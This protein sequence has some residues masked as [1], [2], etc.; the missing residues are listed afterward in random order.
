MDLFAVMIL[1]GATIGAFS[2]FQVAI[3]AIFLQLPDGNKDVTALLALLGVLQ[4]I[5]LLISRG[6]VPLFILMGAASEPISLGI[7][8]IA[9][10]LLFFI[11]P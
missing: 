3:K 6:T 2:Y 9:L 8:I 11:R 7:Y 1:A 10:V 5:V 4:A